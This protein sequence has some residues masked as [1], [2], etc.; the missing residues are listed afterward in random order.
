M[1]HVKKL[2]IKLSHSSLHLPKWMF[3]LFLPRAIFCT[4]FH[5]FWILF[6]LIFFFV[7]SSCLRP[8]SVFH[9]LSFIF[10]VLHFCF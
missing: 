3:Y 5:W 1:P 8:M 10:S 7:K 2:I 9:P 4:S 6:L